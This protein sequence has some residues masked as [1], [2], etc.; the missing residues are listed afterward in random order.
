MSSKYDKNNIYVK[1]ITY[2]GPLSFNKIKNINNNKLINEYQKISNSN[3]N[4]QNY[5]IKKKFSSNFKKLC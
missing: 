1:N 2:M 4:R 3:S 5:H